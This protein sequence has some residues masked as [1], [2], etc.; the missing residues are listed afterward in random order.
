M[1][2]TRYDNDDSIEN[3]WREAEYDI[4][5]QFVLNKNNIVLLEE[6]NDNVPDMVRKSNINKDKVDDI[7][8]ELKQFCEFKAYPVLDKD[9]LYNWHEFILKYNPSIYNPDY[10]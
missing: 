10:V 1:T 6:E 2:R 3:T 5:S 8:F 4:N 9:S 7:F